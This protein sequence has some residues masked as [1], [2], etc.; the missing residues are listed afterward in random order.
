LVE[1]FSVFEQAVLA[2]AFAVVGGDDQES[3]V[4]N[5]LAVELIDEGAELVVEIGEAAIVTV[6]GEA[7]D[8]GRKAGFVDLGPVVAD[9]AELGIGTGW[10]A[11]AMGHGAGEEVGGVSVDQVD[12]CK[13]GALGLFA[14][15]QPGEELSVYDLGVFAVAVVQVAGGV[16]GHS[17]EAADRA[18]DLEQFFDQM[19]GAGDAEGVENVVFIMGEAA[20]EAAIV[21]AIE[22]VAGESG[23]CVA[24][25]LE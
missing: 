16:V 8:G 22:G 9:Q 24:E 4:E 1:A 17:E 23:G 2:E 6:A 20:I 5:A 10:S 15:G 13:E 3:V 19:D 12:E 7:E 18:D 11:E 21:G 25:F 14:L